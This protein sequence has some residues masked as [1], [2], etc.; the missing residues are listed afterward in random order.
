MWKYQTNCSNNENFNAN[1]FITDSFNIDNFNSIGLDINRVDIVIFNI[2]NVDIVNFKI[3][4]VTSNIKIYNK[5]YNRDTL[6]KVKMYTLPHNKSL[7]FFGCVQDQQ[8]VHI[9][10]DN[11]KHI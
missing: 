1:N 8:Q 7:L 4:I 6:W 3:D 11:N 9:T 2:D 5:F 10:I